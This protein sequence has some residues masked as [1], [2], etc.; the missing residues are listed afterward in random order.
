[1]QLAPHLAFALESVDIPAQRIAEMIPVA[2]LVPANT[3]YFASEL[4]AAPIH[5]SNL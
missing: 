3:A 4:S 5:S 2:G 1:M